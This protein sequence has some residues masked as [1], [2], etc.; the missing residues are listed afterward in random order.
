VAVSPDE[1]AQREAR[2]LSTQVDPLVRVVLDADDP[3]DAYRAASGIP[4]ALVG[5]LEWMPHG[6]SLYTTWAETTDLFETGKT[7]ITDAHAALRRAATDWFARSGD[8][9]GP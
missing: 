8:P 4:D 3:G 5:A 7:P 2:L 6:G 1:D 9:T